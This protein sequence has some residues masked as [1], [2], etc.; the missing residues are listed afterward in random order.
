MV[1]LFSGQ[2]APS[3]GM[4]S[5]LSMPDGFE[6]PVQSLAPPGQPSSDP[7]Q[8]PA[9][10]EP[11][12]PMIEYDD[13]FYGR[14]S[15]PA[16][17]ANVLEAYRQ[18]AQVEDDD[19]G[20]TL[21]DYG[22]SVMAGGAGVFSGIGWAMKH[23]GPERAG[24]FIEQLGQ[25]AVDYWNEGLSDSAKA[26]LAKQFVKQDEDGNYHWGDADLNTV[27]LLGAQSLLG[28][29]A[30]AGAGA[31]ITKG[32][33]L[34]GAGL[35]KTL[36]VFGNPGG[37]KALMTA[38][39]KGRVMAERIAQG[40]VP[41][42][43]SEQIIRA[44]VAAEKKLKMID[45][46]LGAAGFGLGEGVI[47]G[48]MSG[49]AVEQQIMALPQ[50]TLEQ[51]E[52]YRLAY[53]SMDQ[54]GLSEEE[55]RQYARETLAEDAA[56]Q[57]G[58]RTLTTT[59]LLSAPAGLF[60]GRLIGDRARFLEDVGGRA[61]NV[62]K[63]AGTE[64]AQEFFQSGTEQYLQNQAIQQADPNQE[65]FQD[66]LNSAVG[67]AAAGVPLGAV[68]GA[69]GQ[70][71][72]KRDE[73]KPSGS[74]QGSE[75]ERYAKEALD[76]GVPQ[77]QVSEILANSE[78]T[79]VG[80]IRAL[81]SAKVEQ[82]AEPEEPSQGDVPRETTV[83]NIDLEPEAERSPAP[84]L[85]RGSEAV[86]ETP[87][88]ERIADLE[89]QL[90]ERTAQYG[91]APT[92]GQKSQ[93][94]K[95]RNQI[96]K[97]RQE[98]IDQAA[99]EAATSPENDLSE[100]TEA[101]KAA[102]NY[103]VG[104]IKAF[105]MD[106]S[107]ENPAGSSRT[108]V[109]EDGNKFS[110]TMQGHYGYIRGTRGADGDQIDVTVGTLVGED[111]ES[112]SIFVVDQ[113]DADG[114]FDE[115]K[116]MIGYP[117]TEAAEAAYTGSYESGWDRYSGITRMTPDEFKAWLS[118]GDLQSPVAD[119]LLSKRE[120]ADA[121]D[122]PST[123]ERL[124][125]QFRL[126]H[127]A[128]ER[129]AKQG[130]L[131][132]TARKNV[133]DAAE[134]AGVDQV[135]AARKAVE[136]QRAHPRSE[137]W[138]TLEN[139]SEV[140]VDD[141]GNVKIEWKPIPYTFHQD[142]DGKS[143]QKTKPQ[144]VKRIANKLVAE[145]RNV[146]KR[147]DEGDPNAKTIIRATGWYTNMRTRLR[148]EFGGAADAVA[149]LL[150]ATSPNTPVK[151]NWNF[152]MKI[153]EQ[154][155][156]GKAEGPLKEFIEHLESGGTP[157]NYEGPLLLQPS[158]KKY[159]INSKGVL[160]AVSNVWRSVRGGMAPKARNFTKNLIG[161]SDEATID[162]WAARILQRLSGGKRIPP[163]AEGAVAGT[164]SKVAG[165]E[166]IVG[167]MF[168]FGQDVF[169]EAAEQLEIAPHE[170]QAL[171]WFLEKDIWA[172]NDWTN[173]DGKGGS[174]EEQADLA[175]YS[176]YVAGLSIQ[177]DA[178]PPSS[179]VA[180]IGK[181]L[182]RELSKLGATSFRASTTT[183]L[184]AGDLEQA[185]DLEVT[186]GEDFDL[187]GMVRSIV[188]V[189]KENNQW[190]T[191]IS[192]VL[193]PDEVSDNAHPG[194]E[195]FMPPGT[196][197][198]QIQ[199]IIDLISGKGYDGFTLV[200]DPRTPY[201]KEG[202]YVGVRIQ[203]IPEITARW[204]S[205]FRARV[206]DD[207]L[208]LNDLFEEAARSFTDLQEEILGIEGVTAVLDADYDTLVIGKE[209]YD[210]VLEATS[211]KQGQA[212]RG[213][214][215]AP[216]RT[217]SM[218]RAIAGY[219]GRAEQQ[220]DLLSRDDGTTLLSKQVSSY[221]QANA[222]RAH[223][224]RIEQALTAAIESVSGAVN[225]KV[226]R[227]IKDLPFKAKGF[228]SSVEG[229][230]HKRTNTVYL[231]SSALP[232]VQRAKEV[233]LHE[234]FGH[235]SMEAMP[236]FADV[237]A[238]VESQLAAGV[239]GSLQPYIQKVEATQSGLS[240]KNK[241]KEVIAV[242]A[243]EGVD[244]PIMDRLISATRNLLR[245]MGLKL[246][247]NKSDIRRLI[248][249]AARRYQGGR[250]KAYP[251]LTEQELNAAYSR[252]LPTRAELSEEQ[253]DN[254][255]TREV[256]EGEQNFVARMP[257]SDFLALTLGDPGADRSAIDAMIDH[258]GMTSWSQAIFS[259]T[260]PPVL[261][262]KD[263]KVEAHNGR[264]RARVLERLGVSSVPVLVNASGSPA[265][266]IIEGQYTDAK[267]PEPAAKVEATQENR[268]QAIAI[269]GPASGQDATIQ[270]TPAE[271]AY[272]RVIR[273]S[274]ADYLELADEVPSAFIEP[275]GSLHIH[276]AHINL[277][278]Q[279]IDQTN[280]LDAPI[281]I[282]PRMRDDRYLTMFEE[283][284][285]EYLRAKAPARPAREGLQDPGGVRGS[286]GLLEAESGENPRYAPLIGTPT[287]ILVDGEYV[288]FGPHEKARDVAYKYMEDAGLPYDPPK[289]WAKVDRMRAR[290]IARE[291]DFMR[292]N[293]DD[294]EVKS[295][296]AKLI[297][298][299]K[300]QYQAVLDAGLKVEFINYEEQGDPYGNPRNVITD[301][302]E[303]NHMWVFSTRDGFGSDDFFDPRDNPLLEETE[304]EISGQKALANDLFRVV[305]DY[306]GHIKDGAGFRAEGEE[307]AWRSHAAMF[308]PEARRALT[309]E[310]RGQN[311]W[312]NFGPYAESNRTANGEDTHYADQ[313]IGL[314]PEWVSEDG[315]AD[316]D[317]LL[318]ADELA[319]RQLTH[320]F[321]SQLTET[322]ATL[323]IPGWKE[324]K[325]LPIDQVMA[326][327]KKSPGV[328]AEE[329]YWTGIEDEMAGLKEEGI[330]KIKRS[331][332][333]SFLRGNGVQLD[334]I[335]ADKASDDLL[336]GLSDPDVEEVLDFEEAVDPVFAKETAEES[337]D[338]FDR[339]IGF[340][341]WLES[342]P[343]YGDIS[344]ELFGEHISPRDL[345]G[346]QYES[347]LSRPDVREYL[348][349]KHVSKQEDEYNDEPTYRY[350]WHVGTPGFNVVISGTLEYATGEGELYDQTNNVSITDGF[351][352]L[353]SVSE[354]GIHV[355]EYVE[356]NADVGGEGDPETAR[357]AE[358]ITPGESE[359]YREVKAILSDETF[360]K[361]NSPFP[362]ESYVENFSNDTHFYEENIVAFMRLTDRPFDEESGSHMLFIEELQS[363]WH[364][365]GRKTGYRS[366]DNYDEILEARK[367]NGEASKRESA[368]KFLHRGLLRQLDYGGPVSEEWLERSVADSGLDITF[369]KELDSFYVSG[370]VRPGMES[371]K[372]T[373]QDKA[374]ALRSYL[375]TEALPSLRDM[376]L[377]S[378]EKVMALEDVVPNAPFKGD[379]WINLMM[380]RALITAVDQRKAFL[381]WT[382]SSE[383]VRRWSQKYETLYQNQYDGKM[384]KSAKK[385]GL[386]VKEAATPEGHRYWYAEIPDEVIDQVEEGLP[387]FSRRKPT[388]PVQA[389]EAPVEEVQFSRRARMSDEYEAIASEVM[390]KPNE[391]L[392]FRDR[393]DRLKQRWNLWDKGS[394]RQ[395]VIDAGY[396]IERMERGINNGKLLDAMESAYKAYTAT[397]NIP[398]VM[399]AVFKKGVPVFKDG[400][401]QI[402]D[403][404]RPLED[405]FAALVDKDGKS[406]LYAWEVY[407]AAVRASR[408][409]QETNPD[410]TL[411]EKNF[412]QDQI[413]KIIKEGDTILDASG[414][415]LFRRVFDDWQK[416]NDD[417]LDLAVSVG[418]MD[419]D[420][421]DMW[422]TNDYVPMYRA[423]D[424]VQSDT[425]TGTSGDTPGKGGGGRTISGKKVKSMR[426]TGSEQKIQGQVFENMMMNTAYVLDTMYK[427]VA[428]ERVVDLG[429]GVVM[430]KVPYAASA[431]KFT[432]DQLSRAMLEAGLI[433]APP[434]HPSPVDYAKDVVS[435]MTTKQ[436]D[437]WVTLFKRVAPVGHN[438]VSVMR[439]GKMAY[440]E[441]TDPLL[442]RSIQSIGTRNFEHLMW[443]I[444]RKPKHLLTAMVTA[445]PAFMLANFARDTLSAWTTA[446]V[447][448]VP[449]VDSLKG[450]A[451]AIT[452]DKVLFDIMMAG[453]GGGGFYEQ[454][455]QDLR[456]LIAKKV[457]ASQVD[458]FMRSIVRI[459]DGN[460]LWRMWQRIGAAS[461]NANRIAIANRVL[462]N[463]GTLAEAAYQA[464][465][466]M[467]FSMR[468]D[469]AAMQVLVETVPFLNARVQ[470]L[471]RLYRGARDNPVSFALKGSVI[472]SASL[473]LLLSNWDDERYNRLPEWD[474]D[475]Y[476]HLF[477][478]DQHYRLPKPFE[479]GAMFATVPERMVRSLMGQDDWRLFFDRMGHMF[480]DTFSF[481][482]IP[483][484]VRPLSEQFFNRDMFTGFPI[485]GMSLDGLPPEAQFNARTSVLMRE[486]AESMPDWAPEWLRSPKRLEHA[487]RGYMGSLGMY[488][489]N[490]A[491]GITR[492]AANHPDTPTMKLWDY[493]IVS[494]FVRD[495]I[496]FSNKNQ[497]LL[498]DWSNEANRIAR[499]VK[500]FREIGELE[501][502]E[503]LER[504]HSSKLQVRLALGRIRRKISKV[505]NQ[506]RLV[507]LNKNYDSDEKWE[508]MQALKI[509][510]LNLLNQVEQYAWAF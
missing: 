35:T 155:S 493:P 263:G 487:W 197:L 214:W 129:V 206:V 4:D 410:G 344:E 388:E 353:G 255:I 238:A 416:F 300:A 318:S 496:P 500:E 346:D 252:N 96:A 7:S 402:D 243:E 174:F 376:T 399:A 18:R 101:Q 371:I 160:Q 470:G 62:V 301:V 296:Y 172:A 118:D 200:V 291:F 351:I 39:G 389:E 228:D 121:G 136:A 504:K 510:K 339:S 486:I 453:N 176:R 133:I 6:Q 461:E 26:A 478:G 170:L 365:S 331:D 290:A 184:Y 375:E 280:V 24:E 396:S 52:R 142:K 97:A 411:R 491:D 2:S 330:K 114:E 494:R 468:G 266:G 434:N 444:F 308:S 253:I 157:D 398:S 132:A 127:D 289:T 92:R 387:L 324:D 128:A 64:A 67:G 84:D 447:N 158:G 185:F 366:S 337:I 242:M 196:S 28:T 484:A 42:K 135:I 152:T 408:L 237:L 404:A 271:K 480:S 32:L 41:T 392:T 47:A 414:Q 208:L 50:E 161:S 53:A 148:Q 261:W 437:Q 430:N 464:Q 187:D 69:S 45:S 406:L 362:D 149:D 123:S 12:E 393:M 224:D 181:R 141:N 328:K 420:M 9:F 431:V 210:A 58:W 93:L 265:N 317:L 153:V 329:I 59:S 217:E 77:Q 370:S 151:T 115:H 495:P 195:V 186:A 378:Y 63:G 130:R 424:L 450:A 316:E 76:R 85:V 455:R 143:S 347:M 194:L 313:K 137:G 436:R 94:T 88:E 360:E 506:L 216:T 380:K 503:E 311:S 323:N 413:D 113:L 65:P 285:D 218:Q 391:D 190:D 293:P 299:T 171:A 10:P 31:A 109:D 469:F 442:L 74:S 386:Q 230:Y 125:N 489:L 75:V 203:Y 268:L 465:D 422:R 354:M 273:N 14:V 225:V 425:F 321:Y 168:G 103:K 423:M 297:E 87:A 342:M 140:K 343:D 286:D 368:A 349:D 204:D 86:E 312:V 150:G 57:A 452:E 479:V 17:S 326:K 334:E 460:G 211:G 305:H 481:N 304:F 166:H 5:D 364:Q 189:S 498:Y 412:T 139:V 180:K 462:A 192:R 249:T 490:A 1:N 352:N 295:A 508:R 199:P 357:W 294:P 283:S 309:T 240:A 164:H 363:D 417:L 373:A 449:L 227:R 369:G 146:Q 16:S 175:A 82:P 27:G 95:I 274:P 122:Q 102:G 229:V 70:S 440:Y 241:A 20:V 116:V 381:G 163:R 165:Q 276:P 467:N 382:H 147:A 104:R 492:K 374:T 25:D 61:G 335:T 30:G 144:R 226:V 154:I 182:R 198:E 310:T 156:K 11:S 239:G 367:A 281:S 435:R 405:I 126:R 205:D 390:E 427:H 215:F 119:L 359:N 105:G 167:S 179:E 131:T 499:G 68:M 106:I 292:H 54:M 33:Q 314:L 267:V 38:A 278:V 90:E 419:P 345:D 459:D 37:R 110:N 72:R 232:S 120:V 56:M 99:N 48:M 264:H 51:S 21:E 236:G 403:N 327:I 315:S 476:W 246:R 254:L 13:P 79:G 219:E 307:N 270:H 159:G 117:T 501:Q 319:E 356:N 303:N 15:I 29:A 432:G 288:E 43:A 509:Q 107:V 138:A 247:L 234:V 262:V 488:A 207:P 202:G 66:V 98:S 100:P 332:L 3:Y 220:I 223:R 473:A 55:R 134:K 397:K 191:F 91:E 306:F 183:G 474:K 49:E 80:R 441:V 83:K 438:I 231:V 112:A 235:A 124:E 505:N 248:A 173:E 407:A 395:G 336:D 377:E 457:P 221:G 409:I 338:S 428:M 244:L 325:P 415:P 477:V 212:V 298:E 222:S 341:D 385:L 19:D 439:N 466:V 475:T 201:L 322:A 446:D 46:I 213:R 451:A 448:I 275:D 279:Y 145:V 259:E 433:N 177:Q 178:P 429:E 454:S 60:F 277:L 333:V 209:Y 507:Q 497:S 256:K 350:K 282:P 8:Q 379:A 272:W 73:D 456:K 258:H 458:G 463:G 269:A 400:I 340:E 401:F 421:R 188:R 383:Q 108:G 302:I 443:Q 44:G 485:I 287:P 445:D 22:R 426:L 36:Q 245:K 482:P 320:G 284:A 361:G 472:L 162:V 348:I 394:I 257:V 169:R 250:A 34:T 23:L 358:Y 372:Y 71:P 384:L 471:Y 89:R 355:R 81:Q 111:E 251:V 40:A 502:A 483:Q 260:S 233:F 78:L 418:A 193:G